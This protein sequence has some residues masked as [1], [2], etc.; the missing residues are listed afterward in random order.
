ME[1]MLLHCDV[2][3]G[4]AGREARAKADSWR[5]GRSCAGSLP[6]E[7]GSGVCRRWGSHSVE[8]LMKHQ[9]TFLLGG[10][11]TRLYST[12]GPVPV[13]SVEMHNTHALTEEKENRYFQYL[14]S[15]V[16]L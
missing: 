5:S 13:A 10:F 14:V 8:I 12:A 3:R 9:A 1:S 7:L 15:V 6:S 16:L 2:F 11:S 4:C